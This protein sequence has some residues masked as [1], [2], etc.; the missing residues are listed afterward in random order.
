MGY[1]PWAMGFK[2]SACGGHRVVIGAFGAS[3]AAPAWGELLAWCD[4]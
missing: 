2:R 4:I 3:P 1:G